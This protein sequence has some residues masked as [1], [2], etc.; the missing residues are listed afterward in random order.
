MLGSAAAI[1]IGEGT[2]LQFGWHWSIAVVALAVVAWNW[3]F[4]NLVWEFQE[5]QSKKTRGKLVF[6]LGILLLLGLGTFLYPMRFIEQ[7][8]WDGILKG[9]ATAV[10]F[11]G[12][13]LWLLFKFGKGFVEFDNAEQKHVKQASENPTA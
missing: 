12:T 9:L 11:L 2:G 4:W 6:H 13:V 8:H 3:R 7:S 10:T 5:D 1:R